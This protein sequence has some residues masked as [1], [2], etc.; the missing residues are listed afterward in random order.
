MNT[1]SPAEAGS[2]P[3]TS[4]DHQPERVDEISR[5][6]EELHSTNP[7]T[8]SNAAHRLGDLHA[9]AEDLIR[10]LKEDPNSYVRS[11][12]AEALGHLTGEASPEILDELLAAIDD[13]NDYVCSA[14][15]N[16]LGLLHAL[17]AVEQIKAC[18][19]DSNPMIVQAAILALARIAPA[20]FAA[21]LE[22]FL[23]SPHYVIHL[24]AVRA[25]GYLECAPAGPLIQGYLEQHLASNT[26][27]DLKLLK[28]YIEVLARLKV[29]PAIPLLIEIARHEIGLRS[30]AVEA[31]IELNAEEA[32]PVLALQLT[33]PSNRLRRNLIEMMLQANY[34]PALPLIRSLLHD[35]SISIRESALAAVSKWNDSASVDVVR[36]M[37]YSDPNP[38]VRPQAV[39][40]LVTISGIE[41]L[42]DLM[43]L[44]GDV[45]G[46][47]RRAVVYNLRRLHPLPEKAVSLLNELASDPDLSS[48]VQEVLATYQAS[49]AVAPPPGAKTANHFV[50]FVVRKDLPFLL[51]SLER[52]QS[53]LTDQA[54]GSTLEQIAQIDQ[55]LS[56]LIDLL[57]KST[58]TGSREQAGFTPSS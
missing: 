24:A 44:A 9:G 1:P 29:K 11:A 25:A 58:S 30:T 17:G 5:C 40:A 15:I 35:T 13:N 23:S 45:N 12:S 18:L 16:S 3:T 34:R 39:T 7:F 27:R 53:A 43:A 8:R 49:P 19:G 48:L 36:W 42:P 21:E 55:A 32:A 4:I 57:K 52:W 51:E 54:D 50:P 14:V 56:S 33:D 46:H 28:L 10:A 2:N 31:L 41:A 38:F 47:V 22:P 37:A 26:P 20:G 6:L